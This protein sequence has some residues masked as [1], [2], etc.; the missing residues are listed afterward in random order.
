[1]GLRELRDMALEATT[2]FFLDRDGI[3]PDEGGD[4]WEAEY[5]RQ[6]ELLKGAA[7]ASAPAAPAAHGSAG[8]SQPELTGHAAE[9]R[10]AAIADDVYAAVELLADDVGDGG[11]DARV[12]AVCVDWLVVDYVPHNAGEIVGPRQAPGMRR[13]NPVGIAFHG[14]LL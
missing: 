1:M 10:W 6:Y 2:R 9:K 8:L 7:S 5:R 11:L 3:L 4:E 12:E 13:K 14:H